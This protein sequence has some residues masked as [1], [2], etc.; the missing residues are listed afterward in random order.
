MAG[1]FYPSFDALRI[2]ANGFTV[3][4]VSETFD[5]WN[6]TL[7][8]SEGTIASDANGVVAEGAFSA[9]GEVIEISHATYPLTARFTLTLTQAEAYTHPDNGVVAYI[10]E[11]LTVA[12]ATADFTEVWAT[13]NDNP[14]V[15]PFK[16]ADAKV[17]LSL[18]PFQSA[19]ARNFTLSLVT[20]DITGQTTTRDL[21]VAESANVSIPA[22]TAGPRCIFDHF[23][24]APTLTTSLET[25]YIDQIDAG[26]LAVNGDKVQ[27]DY[28]GKFGPNANAKIIIV[29]FA[30]TDLFD[31]TIFGAINDNGT[32]W[33]FE[34]LIIRVSNTVVRVSAELTTSGSLPF[35]I[36]P[37][38]ITGLNLTTT[39]YDLL[40]QAQTPTAVGDLTAKM[41]Y[42]L[43][44]PAST[45]NT[46]N[47]TF[48]GETVTFGG[49]EVT[50]RP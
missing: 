13:D 32:G 10:A 8:V 50:F 29:N 14:D 17:G 25:L 28:S 41:A 39:D 45:R 3:P 36:D 18:I 2:D 42:G 6:V 44:I 47:V 49:D 30:G 11:D 1:G 12:V 33:N 22:V 37:V 4:L 16:L 20:H 48:F 40:L 21:S 38:D 34:F 24:D 46:P 31:S 43:F 35:I 26:L 5:V 19:I 15:K 27:A 7:G 23:T 9:P